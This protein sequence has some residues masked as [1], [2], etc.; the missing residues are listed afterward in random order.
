MTDSSNLGTN[1][2]K[3]IIVMVGLPAS[4]KSFISNKLCRYLSFFHGATCTVFNNGEYRREYFRKLAEDAKEEASTRAA[5]AAA[6]KAKAEG[7][8][9]SEMQVP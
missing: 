8:G 1:G 7:D 2:D 5:A 6:A 9:H 3:L 4:G